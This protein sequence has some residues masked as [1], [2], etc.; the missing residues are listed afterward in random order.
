M[1]ATGCLPKCLDIASVLTSDIEE[2]SGNSDPSTAFRTL[3]STSGRYSRSTTNQKTPPGQLCG[4]SQ[5]S[6]PACP[7]NTFSHHHLYHSGKRHNIDDVKRRTASITDQEII[8]L[9]SIKLL[10]LGVA[11]L[12][13]AVPTSQPQNPVD[14]YKRAGG[15]I[16]DVICGSM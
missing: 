3:H 14:V 6:A 13:L 11:T 4:I 2:R 8:M 7:V 9:S 12:T 5:L 15:I 1:L 10:L 16:T